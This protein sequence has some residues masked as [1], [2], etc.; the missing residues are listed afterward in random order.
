M[1][2]RTERIQRGFDVAGLVAALLS[3]PVIILEESEVAEPWSTIAA[4]LNW[5]IWTT[6]ALELVVMLAITPDRRRW[7]REHPIE[8]LVVVLTPPF[9]PASLQAARALRLLQLVRVIGLV[10]LVPRLFSV[11][12]LRYAALIAALTLLAGGTAFSAVET[13]ATPWDGIWWAMETMSTVGYG[14]IVPRTD[15]GRVIGIVVMLIGIG[16]AT[17]LI[18][19]VA[20]R[21]LADDVE[22][23]IEHVGD[24][25]EMLLREV[26]E[27]STR[28]NRIEAALEQRAQ[29]D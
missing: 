6:F 28:L 26:R 13:A 23:E 3:I 12:G 20:E 21:F 4:G 14:D 9:L 16:F 1:S 10:R 19:S 11:N 8:P 17:V 24:I 15:A 7:L 18:G 5:A 27:L 25:E 22:D 2:G 29:R